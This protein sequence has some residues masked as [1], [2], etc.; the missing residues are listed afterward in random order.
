MTTRRGLLRG[1]AAAGAAGLAGCSALEPGASGGSGDVGGAATAEPPPRRVASN[2]SADAGGV[3]AG[4][5]DGDVYTAVYESVVPSVVLVRRYDAG[6]EAGQG[7][8]FVY[9]A[10]GS[11]GPALVVTNQHVV[12][13][14]RDVTVQFR[15]GEWREARVVGTDVYSDLAVLRVPSR[16][17]YARPLPLV[18]SEPPIGTEVVALG[19]PF[20]LGDSASV[21]VVSGQNRSLPAANDFRISD[22]VQTDAAVNPGN[23]G[24]PLVTLDGRVVGVV[25]AGGGDNVGF[26][27]SAAVVGRVAPALA[28]DGSF[29]HAY[30][31]IRLTDVTP[32]VAAANDLPSSTGVVVLETVPGGPADG[33]LEPSTGQARTFGET[34]P[35]GGDVV[36]AL[37]GVETPTSAAL[38]SYLVT[39]AAPGD[40]ISVRVRRDGDERTVE[41]TL[42]ERPDP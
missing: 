23:S 28:E 40:V 1:L 30:M 19:A 34:V 42:G 22:A 16:P 39:E 10:T 3:Q 25:T 20:G 33:V 11:E 13:D 18:E 2:G 27:V 17:P 5:G 8:G 31:G 14:A 38:G 36:L 24:G 9:R 21:G 12:E 15:D 7:S 6:G 41:L 29:E 35:T 32:A 37:D 26:A 4:R